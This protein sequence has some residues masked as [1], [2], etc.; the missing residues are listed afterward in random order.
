[1]G[2]WG[3]G[4]YQDDEA[5][6]LKN[7]I[8]LLGKIPIEGEGILEILLSARSDRAE[9]EAEGGPAFWLVVADQ[10][11]K[12]GIRCARVLERALRVIESGADLR[13]MQSR[14]MSAKDLEKR[15][16]VLDALAEQLKNPRPERARPKSRKPPSMI[17]ETGEVYSF[18]TMRGRAINPWMQNR[19]KA[20]FE[21]DGWGAMLILGQGRAYDWLPW[22]AYECLDTPSSREATLEDARSSRLLTTDS[23]E[24]AVPRRLHLQRL[25][26]DR[27]G[28]LELDPSKVA[29]RM[30]FEPNGHSPEEVVFIGWSFHARSSSQRFEAGIPVAELLA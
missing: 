18:P 10:F 7:T 11:E 20:K 25:A 24:I 22:C 12:W 26:A 4:L 6:D 27:L 29:A 21:P 3:P 16:K 23:A 5:S 30:A 14:D 8:A 15:T 13:D 2:T 17:V 1:M 9:L 19:E 28:R